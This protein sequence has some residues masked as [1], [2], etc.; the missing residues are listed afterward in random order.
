MD[1][2]NAIEA[3]SAGGLLAAAGFL[4]KISAAFTTVKVHVDEIRL[5]HIPHLEGSI[6]EVKTDVKDLRTFIM[7]RTQ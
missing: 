7:K 2:H 1:L 5:N 6:A 4:W 3:I